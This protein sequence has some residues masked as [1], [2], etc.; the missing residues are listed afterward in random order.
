LR[1]SEETE[2]RIVSETEGLSY[3]YLKELFLSSVM[4]WMASPG[5]EGVAS[6]LIGRVAALSEEMK[7]T[8]AAD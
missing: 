5:T 2:E 8:K 4:Q 7:S 1:L 6:I 3:A